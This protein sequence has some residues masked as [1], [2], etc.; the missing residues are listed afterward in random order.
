MVA[1]GLIQRDSRKMHLTNKISMMFVSKGNSYF[2]VMAVT[3]ELDCF[4]RGEELP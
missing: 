2:G 3:L 4:G 1:K